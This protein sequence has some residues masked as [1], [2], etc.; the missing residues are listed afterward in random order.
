MA[1]PCIIENSIALHLE[2]IIKSIQS[3][4][5]VKILSRS[6]I[7]IMSMTFSNE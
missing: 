2:T 4:Q 1:I 6:W 3:T 7:I 5:F